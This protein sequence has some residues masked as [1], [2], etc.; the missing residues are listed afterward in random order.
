M[1]G[2][3]VVEGTVAMVRVTARVG[4]HRGRIAIRGVSEAGVSR[5]MERRVRGR[6]LGRREGILDDIS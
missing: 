5:G 1:C 4:V 6:R 3:L 2:V